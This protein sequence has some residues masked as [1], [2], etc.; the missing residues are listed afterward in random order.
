[1]TDVTI[2]AVKLYATEIKEH[3]Q[4]YCY[5]LDVLAHL[6]LWRGT[7]PFHSLVFFMGFL[8]MIEFP[9]YLPSVVLYLVA[10]A[11]LCNNYYL[12]SH[13][14]PW[15]RVRS[16]A[17]VAFNNHYS[18]NHKVVIEPAAGAEEAKLQDRLDEYKGLRVT[19]FL[20][21]ATKTALALYR[22]YSKSTPV[23]ISTVSKSGNIFSKLYVDYLYYAHLMLGSKSECHVFRQVRSEY[24]FSHQP[25]HVLFPLLPVICRYCRLFRNFVN[26][27][28]GSAYKFTLDLLLFATTWA[29][30]P[31]KQ[32]AV[33]MMLRILLVA[34]FGPQNRIIDHFWIRP[35]YR[36]KEDLVRDGIP[37]TT[38]EMKAD[39]LRRPNILDPILSSKWAYELGRSGRIVVE[40]NLKLKAARE[41]HFGEY[42][43]TVPA[44]DSSRFASVPTSSSFAQP[45]MSPDG[46]DGPS[47]KADDIYLDIQPDC[48][49]WSTVRNQKLTGDIIPYPS[50]AE[51]TLPSEITL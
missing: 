19:A 10:Y 34:L 44:V 2:G 27:R 42:S 28:A 38:E 17:R 26:W 36:T 7:V 47:K 40:D 23:D 13:P 8:L 11:L 25:F 5:F 32:F 3:W 21:Q 41:L 33:K 29:L 50:K 43:E 18:S 20:Y 9:R 16:F 1:M 35:Y 24:V 31:Y 4:R 48:K 39:I 51:L 14:S 49:I 22:V 46:L 6:V 15:S 45:Y 37:S 12:S 30:F